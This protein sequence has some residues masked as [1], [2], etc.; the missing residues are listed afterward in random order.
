[1]L[2]ASTIFNDKGLNGWKAYSNYNSAN[3]DPGFKELYDKVA[4][5]NEKRVFT[6]WQDELMMENKRNQ[7]DMLQL[8]LMRDQMPVS[9]K[10][11][12]LYLINTYNN[13]KRE[14]PDMTEY[15]DKKIEELNYLQ[16][17]MAANLIPELPSDTQVWEE[18]NEAGQSIYYLVYQLPQEAAQLS[19]GLEKFTFRYRVNDLQQQ[20]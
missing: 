3:V 2:I 4:E 7:E 1:M 16:V 17:Y 12:A 19:P 15:A 13:L 8:L 5:A 14:A 10:D 6:T 18:I 11:R 9:I 20:H